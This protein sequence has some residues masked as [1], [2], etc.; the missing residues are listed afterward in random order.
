M[1]RTVLWSR[2]LALAVGL[3]LVA[4]TGCGPS[5]A[6]LS[7]KVSYKGAA[8]KGGNVTLIPSDGSGETFSAAIQEDGSYKFEQLKTGKYKVV[9][10]TDSLKPQPKFGGPKISKNLKNEPPPGAN[11]PPE[12]NYKMAPPANQVAAE[13]AKRYVKIPANYAD[14]D[15]S[16]LSVEV[17][18]GSNNHDITLN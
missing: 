7:G 2:G 1:R 9:V 12:A 3:A 4:A 16:G 18:G 5:T 6:T 14:P 8:L 11:I 15:Q 13:N 17:K 10:E